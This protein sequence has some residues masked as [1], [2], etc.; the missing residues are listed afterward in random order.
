MVDS[1]EGDTDIRIQVRDSNMHNYDRLEGHTIDSFP[2]ATIRSHGACYWV[3][4]YK[5]VNVPSCDRCGD[6]SGTTETLLTGE[7]L[8]HKCGPALLRRSI[9][10][11]TCGGD[12]P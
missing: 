12:L 6:P 9:Y 10:L 2:W 1:L 4:E 7:H 8:C 3:Y 5:L 11:E